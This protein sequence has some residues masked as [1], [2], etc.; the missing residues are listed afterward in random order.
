MRRI[1]IG[2]AAR[3]RTRKTGLRRLR[4]EVRT[5]EYEDVQVMWEMLSSGHQP[6][7]RVEGKRHVWRGILGRAPCNLC[8]GF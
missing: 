3:L 6:P 2:V 5:C 1:L 7:A 8:F 4:R